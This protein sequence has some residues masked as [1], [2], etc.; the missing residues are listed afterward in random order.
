MVPRGQAAKEVEIDGVRLEYVEQG[1][2]EP[3]V[4]VHGGLHDLRLGNR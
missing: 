2:G 3:I 1:S 4:F